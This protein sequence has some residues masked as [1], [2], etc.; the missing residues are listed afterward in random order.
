M[1]CSMDADSHAAWRPTRVRHGGNLASDY[2]LHQ[3]TRLGRCWQREEQ[4]KDYY[5]HQRQQE[6]HDETADE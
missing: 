6:Q 2:C 4:Y 1:Q 3:F 5:E